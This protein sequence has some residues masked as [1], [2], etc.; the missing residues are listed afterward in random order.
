[1][2]SNYY[3][4]LPGIVGS[5]KKAKYRG[6]FEPSSITWGRFGSQWNRG[7]S[8]GT[9]RFSMER[10]S[11]ANT[12]ATS[13]QGSAFFPDVTIV[14]LSVKGDQ[15]QVLLEVDLKSVYFSDLS[16]GWDGSISAEL[17]FDQAKYR[18]RAGPPRVDTMPARRP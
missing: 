3:I 10:G 4:H 2:G 14:L 11:A 5:V 1:M 7:L 12:V 16:N 8:Q 15:E 6:W 13:A 17:T 18:V 9:V